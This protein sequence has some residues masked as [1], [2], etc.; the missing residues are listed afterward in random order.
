MAMLINPFMAGGG[1]GAARHAKAV[2]YTGTGASLAVTGVG[3]QP[4]LVIPVRYDTTGRL[5]VFDSTRGAGHLFERFSLDSQGGDQ[6]LSDM[7]SFDTDGFTLGSAGST[8]SNVSGATYVALCFK[9]VSGGFDIASFTGNG[10]T[11]TNSHALG[12][13]ADFILQRMSGSGKTF[14]A[15]RLAFAMRRAGIEG[16]EVTEVIMGQILAAGEGQNPARRLRHGA[17]RGQK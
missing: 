10:S 12:V 16:G 9:K 8:R 5:W 15:L 13:A 3:F 1:A 2:L 11:K 14:T 4:D 17:G 7:T 6:T